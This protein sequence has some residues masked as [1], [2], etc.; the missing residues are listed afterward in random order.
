MKKALFDQI[1]DSLDDRKDWA[2]RQQRNYQMRNG[3]IRRLALPYKNAPDG[4][5]PLG[6]TLI[7]KI[8]PGYVQQVYGGET[9]ATFVSLKP[10]DDE[11]TQAATYYL[12]YN[13]K[14]KSNFE[15][16]IHVAIDQ[17]LEQGFTPIKVYWDT[18]CKRLAFEQVD[19]LH[20]IVPSATQEYNQN[21][22][23]D[24]MVHVLHMSV[25][26]Y[27]ANSKFKQ[28]DEFIKRI[29][30]K[31]NK[32]DSDSANKRQ[33]VDLKEGINCSNDENEIV[34]WEV[35]KRDRR[36]RKIEIETISPLIA[37]EDDENV[38][39]PSF[40]MPYSKGCFK[41]GEHF[42]FGKLRAEIKG[43]G[44]YSSRGIME[45]NAPFEMSLTK[46]LNTLH[47][48]QDFFS[49][50]MFK[51]TGAS[52]IPNAGNWKSGPGKILP[53]GLEP[54]VSAVRPDSLREDMNLMRALAEDRT[55]IPD[56][57]ASEHL[58][59]NVPANKTATGINALVAQSNQGN[60]LRARTFR[61]D[62]ADLLTMAW[63]IYQQYADLEE[64]LMYLQDGERKA[65]DQ[66]ALHDQY[67]ITPNGSA[68]SWNKAAVV[69]QRTG[70]YQMLQQNPYTPLDEL[71]KY[72]LEA[73]DP[74]IVKRLFRDPKQV[75][76]GQEQQQVVECL[77]MMV[78]YVPDVSAPDDDKTH[79]MIQDQ[80]AKR[81]IQDGSM[82]PELAQAMIQHGTQHMGALMEKKDPMLRQVEA[83]LKPTAEILA[84]Y[85]AQ[86]QSNVISMQQPAGLPEGATQT[87]PQI[88]SQGPAGAATLQPQTMAGTP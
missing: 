83:Q 4:W 50:P 31:G 40:G 27:R 71:T 76:K 11:L 42:P 24:W 2:T 56:F 28:D 62:V 53:A 55:Q 72:L 78:G 16:T 33:S 77:Q 18:D 37:C 41:S 85:A 81:K 57:G 29:K 30:G 84:Q 61:L 68:D 69:A 13:L 66:S 12:D 1:N 54:A 87:G 60:D 80:F 63:G 35:Y 9:I 5:Y 88:S 49:K 26:E 21:G 65:L 43:K 48:W 75:T 52:P 8:K 58:T 73:V 6:D 7:E 10:Q 44:H 86:T 59:G 39:R 45:V 38:V 47:E 22:G 34:L 51:N 32:E 82:T 46:T 79:L 25:A 19:P 15:R 67:E 14:Q 23:A 3:G 17:M 74:R 20:L 64:T 70:L 36:A